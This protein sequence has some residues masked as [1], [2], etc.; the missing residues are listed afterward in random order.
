MLLA[1]ILIAGSLSVATDW[2]FLAVLFGEARASYPEVW[3]PAIRDGDTNPA[4]IWTVVLG[5][6]ASASVV[7]LI[8]FGAPHGLWHALTIAGVTFLAPAAFLLTAFQFVKLDLW[9][10]FAAGLAWGARI[11]IAGVVAGLML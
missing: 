11:L 1:A 2:L 7:L 10:V 9:V 5:F 3:W 4:K 8:A 6:A